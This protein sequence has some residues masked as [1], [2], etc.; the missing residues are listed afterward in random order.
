MKKI[1]FLLLIFMLLGS[2][3]ILGHTVPGQ[4]DNGDVENGN[5]HVVPEP[6]TILLV[7]SGVIGLAMYGR[8]KFFKK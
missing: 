7:G 2:L 8:K 5:N 6:A 3:F 1:S 4:A